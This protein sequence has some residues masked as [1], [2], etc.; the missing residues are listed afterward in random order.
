VRGDQ[1][2]P[3]AISRLRF[4]PIDA[5]RKSADDKAPSKFIPLVQRSRDTWYSS[6]NAVSVAQLVEHRSVAPRVVGSNPIA[7]PK[8]IQ[9]IH[10][11]F[12][13]GAFG[14]KEWQPTS[15]PNAL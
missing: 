3:S 9:R 4:E 1:R 7:H 15:Q 13:L 8:L 10:S 2:E 5:R 6:G 12:N 14:R 11:G